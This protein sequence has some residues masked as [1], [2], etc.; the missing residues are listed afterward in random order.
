MWLQVAGCRLQ[1]A[2]YIVQVAGGAG[3]QRLNNVTIMPLCR[4]AVTPLRRYAAM[5]LYHYASILHI[6]DSKV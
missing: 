2:G 6:P 5:P 4:Y 1:V 3:S